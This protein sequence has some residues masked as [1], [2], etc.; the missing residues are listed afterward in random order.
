MK[1]YPS[2]GRPCRLTL[3]WMS[4]SPTALSLTRDNYPSRPKTS[5]GK[6][7]RVQRGQEGCSH[8]SLTAPHSSRRSA[9]QSSPQSPQCPCLQSS[10]SPACERSPCQPQ[11]LYPRRQVRKAPSAWHV[12]ESWHSSSHCAHPPP[13]IGRAHV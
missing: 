9:S 1:P 10:L 11:P 3:T 5:S 2:C 6:R 7:S 8:S 12:R 13:Q 4:G